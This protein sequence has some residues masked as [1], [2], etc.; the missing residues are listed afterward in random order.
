MCFVYA[1]INNA[2]IVS[3]QATWNFIF[4]CHGLLCDSAGN[5][6]APL[7]AARLPSQPSRGSL[8]STARSIPTILEHP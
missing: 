4:S 3:S 6:L 2:R 8:F 7:R 1:Q 5:V